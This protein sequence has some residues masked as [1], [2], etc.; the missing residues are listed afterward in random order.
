MTQ[1][2]QLSALCLLSIHMRLIY[3]SHFNK[4]ILIYI[5]PFPNDIKIVIHLQYQRYLIQ[6]AV[7]K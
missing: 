2:N 4:F 3:D 5:L 7:T 1:Q 6:N